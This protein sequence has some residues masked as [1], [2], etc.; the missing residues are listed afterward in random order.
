[1][2]NAHKEVLTSFLVAIIVAILVG[3]INLTPV[4]Q[5][6]LGVFVCY[7]C[8][9]LIMQDSLNLLITIESIIFASL[10][11]FL[12]LFLQM[13]NNVMKFIK[14]DR[15][16]YTRLIGFIKRPLYATAVIILSSFVLYLT[17][18]MHINHYI[19][20]MW[21]SLLLYGLFSTLHLIYIYFKHITPSKIN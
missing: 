16:T 11:T 12:G 5:T 1:M 17:I 7:F 6:K 4:A 14:Q 20:L 9:H 3:I 21:G 2:N 13:D 18:E 10:L 15:N 8:K 19:L